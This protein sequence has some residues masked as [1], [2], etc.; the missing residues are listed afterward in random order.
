MKIPMHKKLPLLTA[1]LALAAAAACQSSGNSGTVTPDDFRVVTKPPLSLPPNY[2]L[3]PPPPGTSIPAE[4]QAAATSVAAFGAGLGQ[5]A[6]LSERALVAAAQANA[7]NPA[8]RAQVD[9]EETKAIRKPAS[10]ADR[11]LFWRGDNPEDR[12]S[13]ASDNATGDGQVT[14]ER[15]RQAPR[16]K[17][18]GT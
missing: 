1:G 15:G 7:V 3:R 14:I 17:L 9:Y 8:I 13:A 6:S 11:I 18:P 16:L 2:S 10:I 4:V 12:A 5:D